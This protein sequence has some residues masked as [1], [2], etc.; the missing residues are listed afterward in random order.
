[1]P[2]LMAT[3]VSPGNGFNYGVTWRLR[4]DRSVESAATELTS[5]EYFKFVIDET[6]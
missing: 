3:M 1:V 4:D 5:P 6:E 2:T